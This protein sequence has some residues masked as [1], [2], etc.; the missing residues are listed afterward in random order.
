MTVS[1]IHSFAERRDL[2]DHR[3]LEIETAYRFPEPLCSRWLKR[4]LAHGF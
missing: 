1:T 2:L 3:Y 4:A